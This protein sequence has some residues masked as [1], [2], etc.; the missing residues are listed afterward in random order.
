MK[1]SLHWLQEYVPVAMPPADL[2]EALTMAGLEVEAVSDR[3]AGL[4]TVVTGKVTRVSF[5]PDAD[6]L[7]VCQ[8]E[9]GDRPLTIVCGAPNVEEGM[10]AAV[11]LPG[12]ELPGGLTVRKS[13]IR[14]VASEGM[15]C[16]AVELGIGED[17]AGILSLDGATPVG[18]P[19]TR[20]LGLSDTVLEIDLTPNRAD[21]LSMIGVAREV[22]A[23]S[24]GRVARPVFSV[25]EA[26]AGVADYASVVIEEP[27]LCPRY[28]ARVV[29]DVTVGPS[30]F[31]LQDRLR[32]VG[33]KPINNVV[34]ITNFV[35]M[36]TGQPLH[37]FDLDR[38]SGNRIVVRRA[39]AGERF[40]TLDDKERILSDDMLMIC[41]AEKPV[42]VAGVMGGL[43]SEIVSTTRRVL[44]ES[45][46]FAAPS[47]RKTAKTL[48]LASDASHRFER[49]VD[50][51]GTVF[52][53]DRAARLMADVAGGKPARGVIDNHPRPAGEKR[54][55]LGIGDINRRLGTSLGV[56]DMARLLASVEIFSEPA[57]SDRLTVTVPSFRVD[58]DR[59]EDLAEEVA[60]LWG[61]NNIAVTFPVIPVGGR[62]PSGALA[63]RIRIKEAMVGFGFAEVVNYSFIG[64]DACRSMC[65]E[66][67]TAEDSPIPIL[68]PLS[69]DQAVMRTSLVP[70]L[71]KNTRD[72]I[73]QQEKTIRLF[74]TGKVFLP[75]PGQELPDE[76][77]MLAG[78]WSGA[79]Q[80]R[81]WLTMEERCD[82]YDIKGVL[83]A[84]ISAL[85]LEASFS[86][87]VVDQCRYTLAGRT[88]RVMVGETT[89]GLAGEVR[90]DVLESFGVRQPVFVFEINL[91]VLF[92]MITDDRCARP[93]SRFPSVSRDITLIVANTVEAADLL[94]S[95]AM[96]GQSL[97]EQVYLMDVY[98]GDPIPSGKKSLSI[99]V[100][101]R[102]FEKTL[103]D[104]FVNRIHT[105]T[106]EALV[107]AF[108]A[109]LPG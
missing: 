48:G 46:C 57:D 107:K 82:F 43:N 103:K 94:K 68:N 23:L 54:I 101:Y 64:A 12:T 45:A 62:L 52:A 20:A 73:F 35:M 44:I 38:L 92:P 22:A 76:P 79:R 24:G 105:E 97:I 25:P 77:E 81:T 102:S 72:N 95:L 27:D 75:R 106:T 26:A 78:L 3:Y 30:P 47:I 65:F 93:I 60:R 13:R 51:E 89:V 109:D 84:L 66:A 40:V 7:T 18:I 50:P 31:W 59:P 2:A 21:C 108:N 10:V 16:S 55:A 37:A 28:T 80:P 74:E 100:V 53:V 90:P 17:G 71:L 14:G 29:L 86:A 1:V 34:D 58:I 99:R 42:A 32:S 63:R 15:L 36:E 41:D 91:S 33:L 56:E 85:D 61:Y 70:G 39:V 83:E 87:L 104:A 4:D 88:A 11:A 8:V 69:Q 5:H 49:G 98:E 67:G 6:R 9:T 19:A 96:Q